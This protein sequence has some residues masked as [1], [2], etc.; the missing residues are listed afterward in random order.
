MR[1]GGCP[2]LIAFEAS[3]YMW[4]MYHRN[5]QLTSTHIISNI[6]K[7][8]EKNKNYDSSIRAWLVF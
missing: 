8:E 3:C 1:D 7:K 4:A 2:S 5:R 6:G